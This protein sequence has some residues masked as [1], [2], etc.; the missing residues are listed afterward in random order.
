MP[1]RRPFRWTRFSVGCALLAALLVTWPAMAGT[2]RLWEAVR[3]GG[4]VVL[5][6]HAIAPGTGDPANF[7]LGDCSTQ[8]NLSERGREQARMIG[9]RFRANGATDVAVYSSQWCRCLETAELLGLGEVRPFEGLNSFY[10]RR[11]DRET[12]VAEMHRLIADAP[13]Q[14]TLILV[15]HQVNIT[16]LT[17]VFPRSGEMVVVRPG[18]DGLE[19]LGTL[20]P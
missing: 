3:G 7:E 19:V 2:E 15:T 10:G 13:A 16:A 14:R 9:E 12:R 18:A 6:R 17:D 5:I 11:D 1:G 20:S 8:R 4:H